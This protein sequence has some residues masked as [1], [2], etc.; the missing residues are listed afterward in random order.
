MPIITWICEE[1]RREQQGAMRP[2]E[3]W[4]EISFWNGE[5][6]IRFSFCSYRCAGQW[7]GNRYEILREAHG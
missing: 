2:P 7:C 5:R 3:G 4:C 6:F 1:C